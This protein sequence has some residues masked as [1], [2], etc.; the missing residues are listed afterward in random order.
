MVTQFLETYHVHGFLLRSDLQRIKEYK[1]KRKKRVV[2][3]HQIQLKKN[4][5]YDGRLF[6]H[7][8]LT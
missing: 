5:I 3:Y 1:T 7:T 6:Y 4:L 2:L 8:V